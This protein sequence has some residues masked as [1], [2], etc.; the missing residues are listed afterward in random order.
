MGH[1]EYSIKFSHLQQVA[2][3][4]G[5]TCLRGPFGDYLAFD[6]TEE[7]R[8]IMRSRVCGSEKDEIIRQFV[9]DLYKYEYLILAK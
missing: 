2:L 9:E 1:D 5:Y 6:W 3:T 4:F 7:L 8:H